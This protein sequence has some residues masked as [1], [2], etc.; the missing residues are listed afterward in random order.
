MIHLRSDSSGSGGIKPVEVP[1]MIKPLVL[2]TKLSK[3][4]ENTNEPM[5]PQTPCSVL[6]TPLHKKG[7]LKKR[8]QM[9]DSDSDESM[10]DNPALADEET[11][12]FPQVV[13]MGT[14]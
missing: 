14:F 12:C 5:E 1:E 6:K 10:G 4:K 11:H 2:S 9:S 7:G 13:S 3:V 8:A